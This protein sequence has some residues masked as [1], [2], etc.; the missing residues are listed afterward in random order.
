MGNPENF[1]EKP[2]IVLQSFVTVG[3]MREKTLNFSGKGKA[4]AVGS[5]IPPRCVMGAGAVF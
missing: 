4:D 2:E 3:R 1:R 5:E